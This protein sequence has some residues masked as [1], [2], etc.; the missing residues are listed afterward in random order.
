M[1]DYL[2]KFKR[3]DL[4]CRALFTN[5]ELE[6]KENI[7]NLNLLNKLYSL[8]ENNFMDIINVFPHT[9]FLI[10]YNYLKKQIDNLFK[11]LLFSP[12]LNKSIVA[13]GGGF[14]AGK[15]SL[16][17][18][19]LGKK[20]LIS[21]VEPTTN[22]PTY[23]FAGQKDEVFA[24]NLKNCCINLT[25]EE[26]QSLTHSERDIY[27]SEVSKSLSAT[28][29]SSK[30]FSW[31][32]L[33]FMDTPGY[34]GNTQSGGASDREISLSQFG[35]AQMLIW[36]VNAKNGV[37][38]ASDIDVLNEI[39]KINSKLPKLVLVTRADQIIEKDLKAILELI[40]TT[41]KDHNISFLDVIPVSNRKDKKDLLKPVFKY[42]DNWNKSDKKNTYIE[43]NYSNIKTKL[44]F[45]RNFLNNQKE[46]INKYFAY[47]NKL[48]FN[49]YISND[50]NT[51]FIIDKLNDF[52]KRF[53]I[54]LDKITKNLSRNSY[55][56]FSRKPVEFIDKKDDDKYEDICNSINELKNHINS[57]VPSLEFF[58]TL[59]S[60]IND[61]ANKSKNELTSTFLNINWDN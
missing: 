47:V 49:P 3:Y 48:N 27:N 8:L 57:I 58:K 52:E 4:L 11:L 20:L 32:N 15:S 21:S 12:L 44:D 43:S 60:K 55:K 40:K 17:N 35:F 18:S 37:I 2:D 34:S 22:I 1:D 16:I 56:I 50:T 36:V 61:I 51:N 19:I 59:E 25:I 28:A 7:G 33:V 39:N 54:N 29:I 10:S 5:N 31:S 23:I 53:F 13:F 46:V 9:N 42:L 6:D 38:S 14:S 26:F 45:L 24:I 30:S 41:L